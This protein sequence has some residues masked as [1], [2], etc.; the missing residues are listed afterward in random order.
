MTGGLAETIRTALQDPE[1]L[2]SYLQSF[3]GWSETGAISPWQRVEMAP[4]S[5]SARPSAV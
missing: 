3:Y 5:L 4:G 1:A 2:R